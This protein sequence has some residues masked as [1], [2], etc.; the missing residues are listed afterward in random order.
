MARIYG[1]KRKLAKN[2]ID[3]KI[4]KEIIGNGNLV[5]VI[6]RME[7][8]LDPDMMHEILDSCA[9]GGGAE[10]LKQCGKIGKDLAGKP[11]DEKVNHLNNNIFN[12]EKIA[13]NE[14]NL[15]S[16][17]F[18]YK[19][20]EKYKCVCSAAVK[21][22]MTVSNL[23]EDAGDRVMPLSYCF[24]CAGSF[25]RHLQLQLGV[26]LKTKKIISSPINSNGQKPCEFIFEITI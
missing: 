2:N 14:N 18:L 5:D 22:G 8:L 16:G 9:C 17:T 26:G 24:C 23:V 21:N 20:N 12:S 4:I 15:L 19:E 1:I 7:K 13:L 11:L 6:V 3:E 25:R 10:F